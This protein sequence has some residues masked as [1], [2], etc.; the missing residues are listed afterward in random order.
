MNHRSGADGRNCAS[1]IGVRTVQNQ[2]AASQIALVATFLPAFLL[3]GFLFAIE[4][5]PT[6]IQMITRVIPARYYVST[7]KKIFLKGTPS[8]MLYADMI[9]LAIFATLMAFLATRVFHKRLA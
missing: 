2:L 8:S 5:M 7:L 6:P 9:P 1:G 4:Q 3:S